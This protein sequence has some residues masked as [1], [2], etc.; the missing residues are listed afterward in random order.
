MWYWPWRTRSRIQCRN[1]E[2]DAGAG[3]ICSVGHKDGQVTVISA[4]ARAVDATRVCVQLAPEQLERRVR[5]LA[6]DGRELRVRKG[7]LAVGG[8]HGKSR[9]VPKATGGYRWGGGELL[10]LRSSI[11][12]AEC[13]SN[14]ELRKL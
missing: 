7:E 11:E 10:G 8:G 12:E 14:D 13:R 4:A 6:N 1:H 9:S 3:Q 5:R 2:G